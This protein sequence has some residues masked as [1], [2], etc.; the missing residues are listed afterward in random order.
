[1]D[2]GDSAARF[3]AYVI[4]DIYN[5]TV[6]K[7]TNSLVATQPFVENNLRDYANHYMTTYGQVRTIVSERPSN[8]LDI[9]Q[10]LNFRLAGS[11]YTESQIIQE[12]TRSKKIVIRGNAGAGKTL[13]LKNHF[14]RTIGNGQKIPIL[15][16]LRGLNSN[17]TTLFEHVYNHAL[18]MLPWIN[19]EIF[20]KLLKNGKIELMLDALDEVSHKIRPSVNSSVGQLI[21][22]FPNLNII[23]TTR[24]GDRYASPA[25]VAEYH[26]APFEK[27][28]AINL[29][30]SI[31][32]PEDPKQRF[33]RELEYHLYEK[34]R[35]LLS[36]PLLCS[37]MLLT[38]RRFAEVPDRLHIYYQ[39]AYEVLFTRHD[40]EKDN[41]FNRDILSNLDVAQMQ[42]VLDNFSAITY[43]TD[44]FEFSEVE[45]IN[46]L[47][48]AIRSSG[49]NIKADLLKEDLIESVS[50]INRDGL[51][52]KFFHRS[53]Q[54][55]FCAHYISTAAS[56]VAR[57][58]VN[59][60]KTRDDTDSVIQ[61]AYAINP[62]RFDEVWLSPTLESDLDEYRKNYQ[63]RKYF[64]VVRSTLP[65]MSLSGD[66]AYFTLGVGQKSKNFGVYIRLVDDNPE[67]FVFDF[68]KVVRGKKGSKSNEIRKRIVDRIPALPVPKDIRSGIVGSDDYTI[69]L[70][71][72]NNAAFLS[73]LEIWEPISKRIIAMLV[74]WQRLLEE[75]KTIREAS[76][77][78]IFR[79]AMV[80]NVGRVEGD[81]RG[82][83]RKPDTDED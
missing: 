21:N 41:G 16:E 22:E 58:C 74:E 83:I 81:L 67:G 68:I 72:S 60:V 54:E 70:S 14:I 24:Y 61:M 62:G 45:F 31:D 37:L 4:G 7:I 78:N 40:G 49:Y 1:M 82:G 8:L 19:V 18:S 34:H 66:S 36:N 44:K 9:Y 50:M 52:Y 69:D 48:T 26:V 55:F 38:Y 65:S 76:P 47:N 42:H 75:R 43:A 11:I 39:Q 71:D 13:F 63:D 29:I 46:D 6:K 25:S 53:F 64:N 3:A 27:N 20:R 57:E 35:S 28:Q 12:L 56:S 33:V 80:A 77:L 5:S 15:F 30:R 51:E 2:V 17:Y 32:F 23:L 59:V 79:R 10:P 73:E